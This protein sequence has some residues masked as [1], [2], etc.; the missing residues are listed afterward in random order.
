MSARRQEL[1]LLLVRLGAGLAFLPAA[2]PKLFQGL[3][4]RTQFAQ[5]LNQLGIAHGLQIAVVAGLI[6]LSLCLML[7][8]GYCTRATGLIAALYLVA[9]MYLGTWPHSLLWMLVCAS[10]V[11]AGGGRWSVDGWLKAK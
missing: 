1:Q 2:L 4:A 11:V 8:L 10:F 3:A 5:Q 7:T 6:E 9:T